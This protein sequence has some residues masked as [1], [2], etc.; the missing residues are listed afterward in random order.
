M[1]LTRQ[2]GFVVKSDFFFVD[3]IK[4]HVDF[5]RSELQQTEFGITIGRSIQ[6][7]SAEFETQAPAIIR[8][9]KTKGPSHRAL[10][11]LD[12]YGCSDVSFGAIR[13]IFNELKNPEIF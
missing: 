8:A 4:D 6:L 12:Q 9:I 11:F 7:V 13:T 10:F 5:L 3:K 2:N 1:A